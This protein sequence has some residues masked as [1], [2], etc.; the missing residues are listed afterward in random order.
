MIK[1][2]INGFGRIGRMTF[3]KLFGNN[4]VE[5]VALNDLSTPEML[6]YLLKYDS[7]HGVFP[8]TVSST[9]K[10]L[11]VDG[12]EV[13]VYAERNPEN[14]PWK[15]LDID[16][17]LECTGIFES[18]E[19]AALHL[20]AGARKVIVSAPSDK[21]VKTIVYNVN[22]QLLNK[23]DVLIS[24]AS[25]TTNCLAPMA[26]VLNDR[27]GIITG[28]MNTIHAYTNSQPLMDTPDPKNGFRKS[29]AAA[30]SIVP[31]TTGAAKAIG[32]VIPELN[33]KLDGSSQRVPVHTGS[34]VELYT[35][36]SKETSEKEV[37]EV[38]KAAANESYGYNEDPI[39][40]QD[41]VGMSY[42]S[43]FDATQTKITGI[44][45]KQLVKSVSWYDNE[46]SFVS[47]LTRLL[48]YF[49]NIK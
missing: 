39:V 27:F 16:V 3:R 34:V 12:K 13:A 35:L 8:Y 43:L 33:G 46:M 31:Y 10:A 4:E 5:V 38:M 23:E 36:L 32:L 7:I 18:K 41:I 17:V 49:G 20:K 37:N 19:K 1:V 14:L 6:A 48:I 21:N 25:C 9:E 26:K 22:H 45:D 24:A 15:A 40:S 28:Q 29:R 11:T 30:D 42:G 47:Q 44:G 2:A